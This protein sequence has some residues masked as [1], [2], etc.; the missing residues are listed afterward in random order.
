[1][2]CSLENA[3]NLYLRGIRDG[4]IQEVHE[5]Y[6][7][8]TYTQ[9]STGVPEGKAGFQAF[10]EDF[11]RRNPKREIE[12]IRSFEDGC[13]VFM[14][15]YQNLNDGKAQW[16][17][18]DIFKSDNQGRI[19]EHWDV[20]DAYQAHASKEDVIFGDFSIKDT[21]RTSENKKIVRRF[22]VDIMQNK[23]YEKFDDYVAEE[24]IQHNQAID[25]GKLPYL[26]YLQDH[27]VTYDF[28]FKVIGQ[29]NYVV[30]YSNVLISGVA[31]ALFDI[32]RLKDN[33]IVEHWDNKEVI[34]PR[35]EL[36]NSGKF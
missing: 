24:L 16:V 15:V 4:Y 28:V 29:G 11:F 23:D 34:P 22:L 9:H 12:I 2:S 36:T 21:G 32:F 1:M 5:H 26:T 3:R 30:A 7:G 8:E 35:E 6:M 27:D 19:I 18:A 31:Y 17:T 13:Y 33:R 10:F 25:S 14:H 20:I